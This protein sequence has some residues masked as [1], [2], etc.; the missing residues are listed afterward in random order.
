MCGIV[1]IISKQKHAGFYFADKG[2]MQQL[3]LADVFRG[4][5]STGVFAVNAHGNVKMAKEA[6]A[7]P[8]FMGRKEVK[9]MFDDIS[10]KYHIV[11]GHNRKATM[12]ATVD[13]NAHPFIEDHIILVHNGTLNNHHKLADTTVDSHAICKSI[14]TDGYKHMLKNIDGAYALIWYDVKLKTLFFTRNA[15]RPLALVETDDRIYLA[16]EAKML[17]WIL[18]RNNIKKYTIQ[19]VP[20]DKVFKFS[21]DDRKLEVESKPKKDKPASHNQ[22]NRGQAHNNH[23]QQQH[24][25][26]LVTQSTSH[27]STASLA[28]SYK[29]GDIVEFLPDD[30]EQYSNGTYKLIGTAADGSNCEVICHCGGNTTINELDALLNAEVIRCK[31]SSVVHKPGVFVRLMCHTPVA[32]KYLKFKNGTQITRGEFDA[33]G[34]CCYVCGQVL[35]DDEVKNAV[36]TYKSGWVH[37]VCCDTCLSNYASFNSMC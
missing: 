37:N 14:A 1:A 31:I 34:G 2:I 23:N 18:D 29:I 27:S 30:F 10:S 4:P 13:E 16:S 8:Y 24:S 9:D 22:H 5:D 28:A 7:S 6:S 15:D 21:L 20:T 25:L 19:N 33:N 11:V 36:I 32:D 35:S 3:L 26:S 12:G 17:D